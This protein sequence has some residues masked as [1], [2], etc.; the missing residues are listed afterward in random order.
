MKLA[1]ALVACLI[2]AIGAWFTLS[3]PPSPTGAAVA[4]SGGEKLI[5]TKIIDGDTVVVEGGE[6]VRL[7]GIDTDE[8]GQPCYAAAKQRLYD[9]VLN[10]EVTLERDGDDKDMYDRLLRWIWLNG[11][12]INEKMVAEGLAVARFYQ[13]SKY[14]ERIAAVEHA[15]IANKLG[16][17]WANITR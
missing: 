2:L 4:T 1:A 6:H 12:N 15:A 9:L 10:K 5:V 8:K 3:S 13:K 11:T 14:T 7:L 17:K 16:C